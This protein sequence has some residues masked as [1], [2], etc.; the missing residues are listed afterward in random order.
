MKDPLGIMGNETI[1]VLENY[2]NS[3][4]VDEYENMENFTAGV[5]RKTY[6]LPYNWDGTGAVVYGSYVYYNRY[7]ICTCSKR[8]GVTADNE[9]STAHN[10]LFQR[11]SFEYIWLQF[12]LALCSPKTMH[13]LE[14][15]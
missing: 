12:G 1:F 13:H 7:Q 10:P 11:A 4:I 9:S 3:K 8:K 5:K 15:L 2:Y 6:T 14:T